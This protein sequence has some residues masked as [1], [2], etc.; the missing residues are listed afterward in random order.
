MFTMK[1]MAISAAVCLAT[2]AHAATFTATVKGTDAIFLAGRTDLTI[3]DPSLAWGDSSSATEDG[4]LRHSGATP[5]E[6]KETLPSS[7]SVTAGDVVRVLDPATGGVNFFNGSAGGLFGPEGNSAVTSS[8][9][10]SFGGISGYS[11]TQGALT[12]VF[13][14]SAV[15]TGVAPPPT[16]ST[17]TDILP[18]TIITPLLGQIF[19]IG[20]GELSGGGFREYVAPT[21]ATRLF[22]GIPDAFGF[23]GV[24]GAYDDN[25]GSYKVRVGINSI[26]MPSV[27][28]PASGLLLLAGMVGFAG[29]SR[30]KS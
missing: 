3:P 5:E 30:K 22:L 11:G 17:A 27:P 9:I 24:P 2:S 6:A 10:T 8:A 28:L 15:P 13:L 7:L 29:M 14:T 16:L 25:D 19:Y 1:L 20:T 12:G 23:N 4:M 26:P 18:N 21:G